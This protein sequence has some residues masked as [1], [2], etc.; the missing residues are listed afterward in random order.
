MASNRVVIVGSG[1]AGLTA[2]LRSAEHSDV[3]LI[4]KDLVREGSSFY[5]QGGIA[6]VL[7]QTDSFESHIEDTL[8]A[9]AGLC[10]RETVER[11]V[12][13]APA[14]IEWL[15]RQGVPFTENTLA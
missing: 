6:A 3:V 2:A 12:R 15:L 14:C 9:G 8:R 1:V 10:H 7:D 13:R 4:T 5:A 11:V